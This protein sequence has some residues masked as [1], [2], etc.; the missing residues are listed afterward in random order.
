M[1]EGEK[2][3]DLRADNAVL[4]SRSPSANALIL[5]QQKDEICTPRLDNKEV[6]DLLQ[7]EHKDADLQ[8]LIP[9]RKAHLLSKEVS[10]AEHL[11][12][13]RKFRAWFMSLQSEK[14]LILWNHHQPRT[15][16]GISPIS[17]L[18][19][20]L[21][22]ILNSD[23]QFI[24]L[25]WFCGLHSKHG[26]DDAGA[27]LA[28]LIVQLCQRHHFDFGEEYDDT[29][30]SLVRGRN[31]KELYRLF[32]RFM[33]SLPRKITVIILVDEAYIYERD[34]FQGVINIFNE[35][36]QLVTDTTIQSVIKLLFTSIRRVTFLNE[37]F[38]QSG[39][40]L[41]VKPAARQMGPPSQSRVEKQM[42]Q[43][44]DQ[45]VARE[46]SQESKQECCE[47]DDS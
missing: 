33:R 9:Q 29:D 4:R 44:F 23:S 36:I 26:N 35:L 38:K 16:A 32:Y 42:R 10:R 43:Y 24:C 19:A 15:H 14:L 6:Q 8:R 37:K 45:M 22:P 13:D 12:D 41:R 21:D 18:C 31:T 20:S 3:V 7:A 47:T 39:L 11:I 5:I 2:N 46:T 17:V 34:G 30:K 28:D 25:T 27:M 40:T 1:R